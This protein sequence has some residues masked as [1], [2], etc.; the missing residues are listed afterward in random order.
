MLLIQHELKLIAFLYLYMGKYRRYVMASIVGLTI[1]KK[2]HAQDAFASL[3]KN[4]NVR[5]SGLVE[6]LN[7]SKDTLILKSDKKMTYV[8]S[9]N[10][11]YKREIDTYAGTNYFK[12][13]LT[14]LSKGKH[15]FVVSVSPLKIVFV[16]RILKDHS[17]LPIETEVVSATKQEEEK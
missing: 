7:A 14:N 1:Q 13:P 12:V 10:G 17:D 4:F 11:E 9:I 15:V 2:L 6:E 8:Y 16:V 5:A 3:E